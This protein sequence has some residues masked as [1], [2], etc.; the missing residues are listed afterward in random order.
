MSKGR[1]SMEMSEMEE[2]HAKSNNS[3]MLVLGLLAV[4]AVVGYFLFM[5]RPAPT[6]TTMTS[7]PAATSAAVMESTSEEGSPSAGDAL[8]AAGQV[9]EITVDGVDMSFSPSTISVKKG[10]T[11]R[12]TLNNTDA[13]SKFEITHD[14]VIDEFQ[15]QSEEI[16]EGESTTF[17][18]VADKAGSFEYY[19]S[20]GEHR[21]NGMFGT[22]TVTE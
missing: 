22:L 1:S 8:S 6:E 2:A 15:V 21:E 5:N 19:C 20:I 14:F 4:G 9:R 17:E 16:G 7:S 18:F 11:V 13:N 3:W 12:V 10:D